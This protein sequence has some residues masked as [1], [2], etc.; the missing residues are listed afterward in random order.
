MS[1]FARFPVTIDGKMWMTSEHYYQAQ[2]WVGTPHEDKIFN[3]PNPKAAAML[4]RKTGVMGEH[5]WEFYDMRSDWDSVKD[6][7]MRFIVLWKFLQH[8]DI[9]KKL[10]DTGDEPIFEHST[11]D[12][13]WAD[14]GDRSGKN[15]LGVILM[16]VREILRAEIEFWDSAAGMVIRATT[17]NDHSTPFGDPNDFRNMMSPV[18][19]YLDSLKKF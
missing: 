4:G 14:G 16:E 8:P 10:L 5:R 15:M 12:S 11:K 9:Q 19:E 6:D 17:G 2:K 13:Y 7:V 3:A 1:N 18:S